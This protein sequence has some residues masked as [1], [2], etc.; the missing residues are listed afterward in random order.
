MTEFMNQLARGIAVEVVRLQREGEPSW[1]DQSRSPLGPVRHCRAV[2]RRVERGEPGAS[3][4]GRKH[5]L[6]PEALQDEL[7]QQ[8]KAKR[9][10]ATKPADVGT[11]APGSVKRQLAAELRL[12]RDK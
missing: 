10:G 12:V 9:S 6:S 2:K 7:E 1:L 8:S 4:V 3:I 5:L 11:P